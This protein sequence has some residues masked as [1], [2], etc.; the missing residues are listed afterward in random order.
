MLNLTSRENVAETLSAA[1]RC[2]Y[3]RFNVFVSLLL[4]QLVSASPRLVG[5]IRIMVEV[6]S[7]FYD[8]V[9]KDMY[10]H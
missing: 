7:K 6:G 8:L 10:I 9:R 1:F 3:V 4:D 5:E 2:R